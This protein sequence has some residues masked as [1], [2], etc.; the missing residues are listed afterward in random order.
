[1]SIHVGALAPRFVAP[2][3]SNP[4]YHSS[5]FG[6]RYVLMVFLPLGRE[7]RGR[8]LAVMG[9]H[10][11]LFD[12]VRISAF[13]VLREEEAIALARDQRG[14]RWFLDRGGDLSRLFD[15]LGPDGEASPRWVLIDPFEAVQA[16]APIEATDTFFEMIRALPPPEAHGGAPVTAPVLVTPRIFSPDLCQRLIEAYERDGGHPSGVMREIGGRTVGVFNDSKRRSDAIITDDA[17]VTEI[18]TALRLNLLPRIRKAF[19]FRVTRIERNIVACYDS[20]EG[21][22]FSEHRDDT[23]RGTAH[24]RFA[25]SINLNAEDYEGGDLVFPEFGPRAYR[26]PTGGAAIFSCSLLHAATPVTAGRRYAFL[27]FFYDEAAAQARE[28]NLGFVAQEPAAQET[29]VAS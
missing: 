8:T 20:A 25:C 15:A 9:A 14:L 7:A 2:T 24:R 10:R 26:P 4:R 27:P 3:V 23:T 18:H 6:G 22:H 17:F 1:M 11:A 12:D 13:G 19:Q 16:W 5:T 28:E 21:G 29:E